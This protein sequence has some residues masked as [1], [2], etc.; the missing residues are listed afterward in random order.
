M[1]PLKKLLKAIGGWPVL[2]ENW[3]DSKFIGWD[4]TILAFR[5]YVNK[6]D[7]NIFNYKRDAKD[8]RDVRIFLKYLR[9]LILLKIILC[10][11]FARNY[12]A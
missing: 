1:E 3:E 8:K 4:K 11:F 5:K 2:E 7:D 6:Y 12:K 9:D 10:H